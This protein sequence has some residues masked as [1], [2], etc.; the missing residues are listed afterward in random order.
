M[1]IGGDRGFGRGYQGGTYFCDLNKDKWSE[2][3]P[4]KKGRSG[5]A[6]GIVIDEITKAKIIHKFNTCLFVCLF[7]WMP[8]F[9]G[10]W[11]SQMGSGKFKL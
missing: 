8:S 3:P 7:L 6:A 1:I 2:G 5:H 11:V 4:L 10:D 9:E